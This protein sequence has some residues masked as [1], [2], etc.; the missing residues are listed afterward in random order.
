MSYKL[1]AMA[2]IKQGYNSQ[3]VGLGLSKEYIT[4]CFSHLADDIPNT[5]LRA[6]SFRG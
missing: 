4:S 3:V 2:S 5:H 6:Y 1:K